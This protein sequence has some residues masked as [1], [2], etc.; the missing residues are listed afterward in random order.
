MWNMVAMAS[1]GFALVALILLAVAALSP[2][3]NADASG[4]RPAVSLYG[5]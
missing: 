2:F 5:R 1:R 4:P 3:T